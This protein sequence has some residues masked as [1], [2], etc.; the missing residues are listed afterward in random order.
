MKTFP[1]AVALQQ[2]VLPNYRAPFFD[3]LAQ[4]CE[5][6]LSLLAGQPRPNE[7]IATTEQLQ[8]AT[9]RPTQNLHFFTGPFYLCWQRGLLDWL[10]ETDAAA[11]IVEANP[12]YLSTQQ[13]INWM[14]TRGRPVIG[15]G[16]GAPPLQGPLAAIRQRRRVHFLSQLDAIIAYSERGAEQYRA[17]G[18]PTDKIF[19]AH[20]AVAPPPQHVQ[21]ERP[22][23]ISD[24]ATVLFVGRLQTRKRLDLL[25][26]AC[27]QLPEEI[28]PD[29]HIVGDGPARQE[30]EE[31][32]K[33]IYP[34]AKF[35]GAKHG[36]ALDEFFK[37]ADLFVL[38]GTGGLAVQQAMSHALPVIVAEGDGTQNDLVRPENG[39]L[40]PPGN[41]ASLSQS[42]QDALSDIPRLRKMGAASYRITREEINIEAMAA[43]FVAVLLQVTNL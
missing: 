6:G 15:W 9:Y 2:R 40:V 3:T 21:P 1:G 41:V 19:V 31:L 32:A 34:K 43:T 25:F 27:A 39:W 17:L 28:Q 14:H 35:L 26:Q 4:R 36:E 37:A 13:A 11:L 12:R 20:N 29:L 18:M 24:K 16:L 10:E 23:T 5:G 38:P 8:V 30:F 42:L 7:S 33:T 22:N